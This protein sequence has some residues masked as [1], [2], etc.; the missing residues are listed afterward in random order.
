MKRV[1]GMWSEHYSIY[2]NQYMCTCTPLFLFPSTQSI[3]MT[4]G[5]LAAMSIEKGPYP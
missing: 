1:K 5:T 2:Q 4:V 3:N